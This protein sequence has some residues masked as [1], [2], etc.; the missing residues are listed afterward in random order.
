MRLFKLY[1]MT[2][3][4]AS[5]DDLL[6]ASRDDA[7]SAKAAIVRL[8]A[9]DLPSPEKAASA[10]NRLMRSITQRFNEDLSGDS[11]LTVEVMLALGSPP[12][13]TVT[14]ALNRVELDMK[15]GDRRA[16]GSLEA[17]G[18]LGVKLPTDKFRPA[19]N[20]LLQRAVNDLDANALA[21]Y[22]KA[23]NQGLVSS[24]GGQAMA[25]QSALVNLCGDDAAA[26]P[27]I[28]L[29][30]RL[31][32]Q[33]NV[34]SQTSSWAMRSTLQDLGRGHL[35]SKV[36][37][38]QLLGFGIPLPSDHATQAANHAVRAV[39]AQSEGAAEVAKALFDAGA[40]ASP[41]VTGYTIRSLAREAIGGNTGAERGLRTLGS[42][43]LKP[44]EISSV[45]I[46]RIVRRGV[47]QGDAHEQAAASRVAQILD[48]MR[49]ENVALDRKRPNP[50]TDCAMS[51]VRTLGS[52]LDTAQQRPSPRL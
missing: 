3:P 13:T 43:G 16:L 9:G 37:L 26:G 33:P 22:E 25:W 44:D 6:F 50:P 46:D 47:A 11:R 49:R 23:A 35:P 45:S 30:Q 52:G 19:M 2:H 27:Q 48:D 1:A 40:K 29:L 28:A 51:L 17:L 15:A 12:A 7:A 34:D 41:E 20:M 14:D 32:A 42:M 31:Q 10:W 4:S 8:Q 24:P 36:T 21:M 5:L 39:A 38:D 18:S